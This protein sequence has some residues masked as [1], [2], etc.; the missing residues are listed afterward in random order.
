MRG[1]R[2]FRRVFRA[3]LILA[4]LVCLGGIG[5][6]LYLQRWVAAPV[7]ITAPAT[8]ELPRGLGTMEIGHALQAAGVIDQPWLFLAA[9]ETAPEEKPLR[10][11]EYRFTPGQ[12]PAQIIAM[13]QSGAVLLHPITAPEGR[14][15]KEVFEMLQASDVLTG[16]LPPLPPEGTLIPD[17]YL[18]PRGESRERLVRRMTADMK[19][20]VAA[21]WAARV[22]DYPLETADQMVT[23]ASIIERETAKPEEYPLVAAV[24]LNRLKQGMKLQTDPTVIYG[25]ANGMGSIGRPLTRADLASDTPYNTYRIDGLPPGPIANPGRKA[26]EAAAHPADVGYLYFVADG[27][28]GHVFATTLQEHNRNVA[29]WRRIE[30][31]KVTPANAPAASPPAPPAEGNAGPASAT[32]GSP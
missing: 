3:V 4:F 6:W 11:G 20:A 7:G 21:A 26:L 29:N 2:L 28:G 8:V 22:Q 23:L 1:G 15:V 12:T 31:E 19:K 9:V 25:L 5:G 27:T 16:D 17:T 30:A 32:G 13:L 18:V 14:T 24:F 10:A